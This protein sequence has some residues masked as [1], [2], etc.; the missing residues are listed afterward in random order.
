MC[1]CVHKRKDRFWR[2][3]RCD[4]LGLKKYIKIFDKFKLWL[5]SHNTDLWIPDLSQCLGKPFAGY[6]PGKR[7]TQAVDLAGQSYSIHL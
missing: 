2:K 6:G 5:G 7:E 3:A 1:M 4:S